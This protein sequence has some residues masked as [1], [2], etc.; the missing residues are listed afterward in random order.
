M[1]SLTNALKGI[2]GI[3]GLRN[4]ILITALI[5]AVFRFAAH[6]PAPGIDRASLQALFNSSQFLTLLDVFSGGTLANFSIMALGLGPYINASIIFQMLT[7]IIPSLE[8]LSKEGEY[9]R[10]KI[11]QYTRLATIPLAIIQAF[12]LI[13]LLQ[14]RGIITITNPVNFISVMITLVTGTIFVLWLGEMINEFGVGNGV[15]V[16]IFA[17][18]VSSLPVTFAQTFTLVETMNLINLAIYGLVSLLVVYLIVRITEATRQIPITYARRAVNSQ[19]AGRQ[20]T[21]LPLRLNQAGVIPIIFAVSM[22]LIPGLAANFL[23]SSSNPAL[24]QFART[25]NLY[26][27]PDGWLYN[28]IYFILIVAFTYFYT[29]VVFNP[30]KIAGEIKKYGGFIPGVR[31]GKSTSAYLMY[32]LNRITLVGAGFLGLIAVMPSLVSKFTGL[33]TLTIGGTGILIVISVVLELLKS[34]QSQ[35]VMHNYNKFLD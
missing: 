27:A 22:M 32:I 28:V 8:T 31:P 12:G 30:D 18:I 2:A 4:K 25:V 33:T 21:Y 17:G 1:S 34:L 35:L 6:I 15:S 11:N 5:F 3:K 24:Q 23:Q 29:A 14:N 19:S 9:G 13:L 16:L 26:L 20:A 10:N 7:L